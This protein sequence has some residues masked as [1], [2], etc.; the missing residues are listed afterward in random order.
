MYNPDNFLIPDEP[1]LLISYLKEVLGTEKFIENYFEKLFLHLMLH[2]TFDQKLC[3]CQFD[4]FDFV[5]I[6]VFN[7][8]CNSGSGSAAPVLTLALALLLYV[9]CLLHSFCTQ[10]LSVKHWR[11]ILLSFSHFVN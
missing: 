10:C 1:K 5:F 7:W 11:L 6:V 2:E 8:F 3:I 4:F 9:C